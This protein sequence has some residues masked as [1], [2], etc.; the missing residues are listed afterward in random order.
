MTLGCGKA[1]GLTDERVE[2]GGIST[3]GALNIGSSELTIRDK[4]VNMVRF[5]LRVVRL[6]HVTSWPDELS[7]FSAVVIESMRTHAVVSNSSCQ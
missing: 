6:T 2:D 5:A 7:G 4:D 1:V 3:R